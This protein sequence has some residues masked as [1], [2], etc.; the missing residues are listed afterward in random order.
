MSAATTRPAEP[1]TAAAQL[2][3]VATGTQIRDYVLAALRARWPVM[4]ATAVAMVCQ[5]ALTLV[6]PIA[7]GWITQAI[8]NHKGTTAII[9]PVILLVGAATA[10]SVMTW[11]SAVLLARA[12]LPEVARL[13]EEVV[14]SAVTLPIGAVEA[15][16]IGDLV[17]RVS[18]DVD[19]VS[20]AAQGALRSF[21]SAGLTIVTT[22]AG[23]ATLDWRFAVAGMLAVPIQIHTLRWYLR[24]SRPIYAGSRIAEG[25]RTSALLGVFGALPTLR[26]LR[27]GAVQV[28]HVEASSA[29]AMEFEF[30]AFRVATRFFGRLNVAEFVGLA[31]ILLVAYFLVDDHGVTV[32]AATTA[33]LF[34]AGLF[35]PINVVLGV[36]DQLQ[37]AGAGLARLIGVA[38]A[39]PPAQAHLE[40]SVP[41]FEIEATDLRFGYGEG[42]DVLHDVDLRIAPGE[43]VAVVGTTGSGKSTLAALLAGIRQPRSGTI[44]LGGTSLR[45][46]DPVLLHRSI[47][48][49]TQE[50]HVF[51]GT[52]ADNLRLVAPAADRDDIDKV[53]SEVGAL[54]WVQALPDRAQT[55]IG[56]GGH[57][58]TASQAQHLALA[59]LLLL[60]PAVV[61]LDEATA[62]GG[63]DAARVLDA[64]AQRVL[65]GRGALIVA[66]RLSPAA[67]A[68]TIL[69][70]DNGTIVERGTH[71]ELLDGRGPYAHLWSAWSAGKRPRDSTAAV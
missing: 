70:M 11:A 21:L 7:V 25:R 64:A 15:G 42:P 52:V 34:F 58:L 19:Q 30:R 56:A 62:E 32:G 5:S 57:S 63:S 50:A 60:D 22:L 38:S 41:P 31:A 10:G 51:A 68:D 16:G 40:P 29:D 66:H 65:A 8:V 13:R 45:D 47:A 37:Q 59:R 55:R 71:A 44:R 39:V 43:H 3:P 35:N 6:G 61:I 9:G 46:L 17:S 2:L 12:V 49:I 18:G 23:L 27:Q 36:F 24:R 67:T 48:L 4:L 33:A 14:S 20:D 28:R 69:V 26:A 53:L 1:R 54:S